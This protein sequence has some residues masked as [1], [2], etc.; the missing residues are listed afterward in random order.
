MSD[1]RG[2]MTAIVALLGIEIVMVV[3]DRATTNVLPGGVTLFGA[4]GA[5]ALVRIAKLLGA[6][7][8]QQPGPD[9]DD[10]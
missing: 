5:V 10:E 9:D 6:I 4:L 7:G 3:T 8:V 2:V 1:V